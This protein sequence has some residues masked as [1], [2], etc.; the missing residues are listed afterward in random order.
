MTLQDILN[1]LTYGEL[2]SHGMCMDG[3]IEDVDKPKVISAIN[4]GLL[5]LYTMFPLLTKELTIIQY[6]F[7]TQYHLDVKYARTN[8]ESAERFKYIYDSKFEPFI[9]DNLRIEEAFNEVGDQL[10]L[11][12]NNVCLVGMTPDMNTLEIP[13]P[14]NTN[15]MFVTYRARHP[16]VTIDTVDLD[17]SFPHHFR[18]ALLAFVGSRVY[19]GGTSQEQVAKSQ[20]LLQK[21]EMYKTQLDYTGMGNL[22]ENHLNCKPMHGGWI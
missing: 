19:S 14:V 21:Y 12:S 10:L 15:A 3:R 2:S 1:D 17:G 6:S 8:K 22:T 7:I 16:T 4:A 11:N 5:D 18:N 20:E 13:N 9:G